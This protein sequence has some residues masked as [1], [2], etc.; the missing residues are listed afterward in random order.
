METVIYALLD[1]R[2][3]PSEGGLRYIG[4]T[5]KARLG[6]R[7]SEHLGDA[8]NNNRTHKERWISSLLKE[9]VKPT[10]KPL[11]T[12]EG[13]GSAAEISFI[14]MF[15]EMGFDLVNA[16]DSGEGQSPGWIPSDETRAKMRQSRL[17][18]THSESTKE[19]IAASHTTSSCKSGHPMADQN[20]Y[21]EPSGKRRCRLCLTARM[22]AYYQSHKKHDQE[23]TNQ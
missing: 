7:Y 5:S 14:K 11:Y 13:D 6:R 21:I 8:E 1:P 17:G 19:K 22:S 15:R 23:G 10:I 12:I 20:L 4:K 2:L 3:P 18:K 16:T 9:G